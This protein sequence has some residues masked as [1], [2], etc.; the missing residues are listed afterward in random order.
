MYYSEIFYGGCLITGGM[1]MK[2][3]GR[4]SRGV[5]THNWEGLKSSE[6]VLG[7]VLCFGCDP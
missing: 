7:P 1:F 2:M 4:G 3:E 6:I 5:A